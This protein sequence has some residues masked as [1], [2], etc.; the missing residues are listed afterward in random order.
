MTTVVSEPSAGLRTMSGLDVERRRV[1]VRVDFN[2]PL[3]K[4][5][6]AI[7]DDTRIR[8]ALPTINYLLGRHAIVILASHLG[9]PK[10][11]RNESLSLDP[12]A[13]RLSE[14]LG[15]HVDM[16]PDC[17]GPGVEAR[18]RQLRPGDILLLENLRFHAEEEKNDPE[19]VAE[20]AKLAD[21][22]VNDA[23]GTAHRAHASTEGVAHILPS[24]AG[25]LMEREIKALSGVLEHPEHPFTAIIGGAKISTKIGVLGNLLAKVDAL[26][27]GG[28][29]ANTFF[30][31]QG[32]ALGAS[33]V[34]S[35]QIPSA[36]AIL[37]APSGAKIRLP[38]DVAI[39]PDVATAAE[40]KVVPAGNIP[41]GWSI[42]DIGP[43][44]IAQFG[45][46]I[47]D[48]RTI[49]WNGPMGIFETPA[50]AKGTLEIAKALAASD[51]ETIVGGGDSVAALEQMGLAGKM[52]HVSTGG[53]ASLEFLEG[54]ELPGI[55]VLKQVG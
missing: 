39:T 7:T 33:L 29:M 24:A 11:V 48:S 32:Y 44:S 21:V 8:A 55:K 12:V 19:F 35:D 41:P 23:F 43:E 54:I 5:T 15:R 42:V 37:D 18:V 51:G 25:L 30:A 3:D 16:A 36:R 47:K 6:G 17:I 50:Y 31:A 52:T 4:A 22:Y 27:I 45:S 10:G 49:L 26:I 1:L 9:R 53:G 13:A 14:L 2:V 34:E 20:L 38:A 28:G 46:L 40:T